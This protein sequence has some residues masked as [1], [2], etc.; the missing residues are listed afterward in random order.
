MAHKYTW[1]RRNAD[2]FK[3]HLQKTVNL[4]IIIIRSYFNIKFKEADHSIQILN[5]VE[6]LLNTINFYITR[7]NH[8]NFLCHENVTQKSILAVLQ[9]VLPFPNAR[10]TLFTTYTIDW[11]I[12]NT[13]IMFSWSGC[14]MEEKKRT[15]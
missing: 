6:Y 15:T 8:K 2:H 7:M 10:L 13:K 5:P 3:T 4:E 14:I 1:R 12:N 11:D 9:P